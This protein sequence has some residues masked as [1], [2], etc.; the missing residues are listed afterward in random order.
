[1]LIEKRLKKTRLMAQILQVV[2][3]IR[4]IVLNGSLAQGKS[5]QE[6]DIDLLIIVKSGRLFTARLFTLF[7][8]SLTG[9]RRSKDE[10]RPH[11][12]KFCFNYFLADNY[13]KIPLGRGKEMDQYCADNYSK[14]V[15]VWGDKVLFQRFFEVNRALF[16]SATSSHP[17]PSKGEGEKGTPLLTK[18]RPGEV[19]PM[20]KD[21]QSLTIIRS[22]K[23]WIFGGKLGDWFEQRAKNFQIGKIEKDPR[24]KKYP[25]LIVYND[26]EARFHPPK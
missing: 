20:V 14:S 10:N 5:N 26:R 18:E 7:L 23:E 8:S 13:L 12:G 2:P 6:S 4:A 16:K 15:L 3:F 22:F 11:A 21:S 24:T 9:Q 17:S 25:D 19:L 1:M